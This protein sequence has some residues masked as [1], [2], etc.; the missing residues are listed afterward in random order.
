[1]ISGG[2]KYQKTI[3]TKY[4]KNETDQ[5]A[6]EKEKNKKRHHDKSYYRLMREEKE[7]YA[8]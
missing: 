7:D 2:K 1:M 8:L 3:K 4:K 5:S 6:F